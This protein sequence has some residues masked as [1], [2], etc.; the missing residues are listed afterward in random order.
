MDEAT[1][2]LDA[3]NEG[4]IMNYLRNQ[5]ITQIIVTHKLYMVKNSD[6]ILV[7]DHGKIVGKGT[8]NELSVS[9]DVYSKIKERELV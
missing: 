6:I 1:N 4:K 7:I 3:I 8:H 5:N 2:N 9:C